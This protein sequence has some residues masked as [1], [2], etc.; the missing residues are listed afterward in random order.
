VFDDFLKKLNDLQRRAEDLHGTHS[1]A[2]TELFPDEFMLRYTEFPSINA[3]IEASGFKV[4]SKD[5]FA[6][7][8]DEQWDDFIRKRT[9]FTSWEEMRNSAAREWAIRR[10]ELD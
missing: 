10:L 3:M 7:I 9:R 4:E 8:P 1:V 6:A 5:D 2:F